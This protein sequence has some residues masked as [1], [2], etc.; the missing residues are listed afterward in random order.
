MSKR[1]R[2]NQSMSSFGGANNNF[3]MGNAGNM[4]M[5]DQMPMHFNKSSSAD[6]MFGQKDMIGQ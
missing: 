4:G 3:D 1:R 5:G 6:G 2:M